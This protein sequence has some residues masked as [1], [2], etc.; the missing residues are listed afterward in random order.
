MS[1]KHTKTTKKKRV[2]VKRDSPTIQNDGYRNIKKS[3]K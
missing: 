3:S 1:T 2:E